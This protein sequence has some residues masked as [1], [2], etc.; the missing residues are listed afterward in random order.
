MVEEVKRNLIAFK[1]LRKPCAFNNLLRGLITC[2]NCRL[3][4]CDTCYGYRIIK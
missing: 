4:D 2:E 3:G 1:S